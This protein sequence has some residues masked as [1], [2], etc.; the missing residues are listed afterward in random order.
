MIPFRARLTMDV[1][2]GVFLAIAPWLFQ[3]AHVVW[4]P[5]VLV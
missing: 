4:V 1:L 5:R 3:F 2:G